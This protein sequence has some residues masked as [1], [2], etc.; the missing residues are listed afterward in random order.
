MALLE[1]KESS[2]V[3]EPEFSQPLCT[4]LQIALVDLLASWNIR[5]VAT[6]GHSSGRAHPSKHIDRK[7]IF[8]KG[9]IGAAYAAGHHTAQEAIILAYYR[10]KV[11]STHNRSG[12][13]LAVGL[14]PN[15]VYQYLEHLYS[16]VVIA[17]V[18]S[19]SS[20]TLS[21]DVEAIATI[22]GSLDSKKIF[23]RLLQTG[24]K[25]YHSHHMAAVGEDYELLV[26]R[27]LKRLSYDLTKGTR[28]EPALWVSSVTPFKSTSTDSVSPKYWRRNLESP[29]LFGPAVEQLALRSEDVNVLIEIGPHPALAGP[30]RQIRADLDKKAKTQLAP[31]FASIIR[32]EDGFRNLLS[33]AGNLFIK[34]VPVDI[35]KINSIEYINENGS[36]QTVSGSILVDLPNY[37][38]RYGKPVY[39]ENRLNKEW[40]LRKH[41][42]HDILGAKQAG[43]AHGRPAW[44][45]MLRLKDVPWLDDHKVS[46]F[47]ILKIEAIDQFRR[48]LL[49]DPIFPAAGY[50]AMAIEAMSQT[51]L[52]ATD[53]PEIAGFSFR[54]VAIN[55]TLKVPD[56]EF[57]V[58]TILNLQAATLSNSKSSEKWYEFKISSVMDDV[59]TEH[60]HGNISI[61]TV[62]QGQ[63]AFFYLSRFF[64]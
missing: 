41:L 28:Q 30:L 18:N 57:G 8:I 13:M 24:G 6:V 55:S 5:P 61:E 50:L 25:A 20:V 36:I 38:Y 32:G 59:W 33:L 51:Y 44:R 35:E 7:L 45:N 16:Q 11:L 15:E 27:A 43:C 46:L 21:G 26:R 14:G 12:S 9:E 52:E 37:Q 62:R 31:C 34:N 10:G 53:A 40:R 42:R 64:H 60:C 22:K 23:C 47:H 29:V 48:Q 54:S 2:R 49:P 39:Y 1:P 19:P 56:D 4:A 58:E 3:Q 17:A 63:S